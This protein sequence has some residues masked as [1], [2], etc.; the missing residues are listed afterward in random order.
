[1]E[2]R[3]TWHHVLV[4]LGG[5]LSSPVGA[6]A[7]TLSAAIEY[8]SFNGL[9]NI[10]VSPLYQ[11]AP[12]PASG[13]PDF[14]NCALKAETKLT[15]TSL[16]ALFQSTEKRL[17]RQEGERW[18]AR[19]LDI[20]LL[21]YD[22]SVFPDKESWYSVANHVDPAAF[23]EE[24]VVPHPRLHKR[25]FVLMPLMGVA[26]DWEHPVLGNRVATMIKDD[27]IQS[28]LTSITKVSANS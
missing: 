6:P 26:P 22:Q 10:E 1:M 12:I 9:K 19:T 20:D 8:L 5:N 4:G 15:A 27:D 13:Q 3:D 21:A 23:L 7:E 25:G 18:S 17:G 24:P 16:L 11:T 14:I 28:Q 2:F